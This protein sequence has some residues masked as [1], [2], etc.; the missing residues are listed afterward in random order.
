MITLTDALTYV[1][2]R[3]K[4]SGLTVMCLD[5]LMTPP[6]TRRHTYSEHTSILTCTLA[7]A[8]LLTHEHMF[9]LTDTLIHWGT[10]SNTGVLILTDT[11]AKISVWTDTVTHTK[12]RA[13]THSPTDKR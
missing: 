10:V 13:H 4:H 9:T 2:Q 3:H 5:T 6:Y 11:L 8:L 7:Y 12:A 1:T